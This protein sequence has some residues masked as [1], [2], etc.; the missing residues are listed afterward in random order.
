MGHQAFNLIGVGFG[1]RV[2]RLNLFLVSASVEH[3]QITFRNIPV[4]SSFSQM[5][6]NFK[7]NGYIFYVLPGR[8]PGLVPMGPTPHQLHDGHPGQPVVQL[9][10]F[11]VNGPVNNNFPAAVV[12]LEAGIQKDVIREMKHLHGVVGHHPGVGLQY[13]LQF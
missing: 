2:G 5:A 13:D 11:L 9:W 8:V 12:L 4:G 3:I 6:Q 10:H 1:G 7:N